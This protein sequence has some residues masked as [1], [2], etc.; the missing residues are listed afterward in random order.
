[1]WQTSLL[2]VGVQRF[3]CYLACLCFAVH[4]SCYHCVHAHGAPAVALRVA[5]PQW[6]CDDTHLPSALLQTS[7]QRA[8]LV[9]SALLFPGNLDH[10]HLLA[11]RAILIATV[12]ASLPEDQ[13]VRLFVNKAD[14]VLP[15]GST[16]PSQLLLDP[17]HG[18]D[19]KIH[20]SSREELLSA[21]ATNIQPTQLHLWT[22]VK[23]HFAV[24]IYPGNPL[25]HRL[26]DCG[27]TTVFTQRIIDVR[28]FISLTDLTV[29]CPLDILCVKSAFLPQLPLL[30]WILNCSASSSFVPEYFVALVHVD[31][32]NVT[33][34]R[35]ISQLLFLAKVFKKTV[36][37]RLITVIHGSNLFEKFQ[38]F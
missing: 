7:S 8:T 18:A 33:N 5:Q 32:S 10:T 34:F 2:Y 9:F 3:D 29:T 16:D 15:L 36:G 20:T 24:F 31:S 14:C 1:M 30:L 23:G 17:C 21:D 28:S 37:D 38:S 13:S 35:P 25:I 11:S 26:T 4:V 22:Q 19:K 12:T 6:Q 27:C